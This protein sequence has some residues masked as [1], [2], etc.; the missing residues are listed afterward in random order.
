MEG[1][2]SGGFFHPVFIVFGIVPAI[3]S[4]GALAVVSVNVSGFVPGFGL[5]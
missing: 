1:K 2:I 3:K 5:T 4:P